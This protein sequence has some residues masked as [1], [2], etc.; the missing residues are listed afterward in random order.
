MSRVAEARDTRSR[1]LERE[2]Y[3]LSDPNDP[4][5]P[6]VE[7]GFR[8]ILVNRVRALDE[9]FATTARVAQ[10]LF[11][12]LAAEAC[13]AVLRKTGVHVREGE[14]VRSYLARHP[15]VINAALALAAEA[16]G[17]ARAG[18]TWSLELYPGSRGR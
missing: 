17:R 18:D 13:A 15:D 7:E 9:F 16:Q 6:F 2:P 1:L 8:A 10:D 4:G 11:H 5:T 12:H 3:V 14:M